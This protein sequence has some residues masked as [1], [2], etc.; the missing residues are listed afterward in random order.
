MIRST[1]MGRPS[2][3]GV[4]SARMGRPSSAAGVSIESINRSAATT[5]SKEYLNQRAAINK[6]SVNIGKAMEA[7][8]KDAGKE[9]SIIEAICT[10]GIRT[11]DH[12]LQIS[13]QS[14]RLEAAIKEMDK[15]YWGGYVVDFERKYGSIP[16][17][18]RENYS[19]YEADMMGHM[20]ETLIKEGCVNAVG[21]ASP[22]MCGLVSSFT[23]G[24]QT[25]TSSAS[26]STSTAKSK[27]GN[28]IGSDF[29]KM[30]RQNKELG[31]YDRYKHTC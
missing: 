8:L 7:G 24:A 31:D 19:D 10:A 6:V 9:G 16:R 30:D 17:T 21:L 25:S 13:A 29:Q 2:S 28:D 4:S 22:E 20:K 12:L 5:M 3:V 15:I 26:S 18:L 14:E 11:I 1:S 23:P 27:S